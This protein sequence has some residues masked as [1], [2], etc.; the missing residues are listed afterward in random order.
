MAANLSKSREQAE[1]LA[2][3]L[4]LVQANL[5]MILVAATTIICG[6]HASI[7]ICKRSRKA[8]LLQTVDP[9]SEQQ[10]H[11]ASGIVL[12]A[13][14]AWLLPIVGSIYLLGESDER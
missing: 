7:P 11:P 10:A 8:R 3:P 14:T 5:A 9:K 6:A 2:M 13:I 1:A 12:S 4:S